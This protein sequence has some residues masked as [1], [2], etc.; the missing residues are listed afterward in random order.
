MLSVS[1]NDMNVPT[2]SVSWC[3][4]ASFLCLLSHQLVYRCL[5]SGPCFMG[6]IA[7]NNDYVLKAPEYSLQYDKNHYCLLHVYWSSLR[8]KYSNKHNLL[9]VPRNLDFLGDES[10]LIQRE[11][12]LPSFVLPWMCSAWFLSTSEILNR[13][14]SIERNY[15][16]LVKIL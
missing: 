15:S 1:T 13:N 9:I 6:N 11:A 7:I 14:K 4:G 8:V 2:T 3:G 16:A 5:W 10:L 12:F